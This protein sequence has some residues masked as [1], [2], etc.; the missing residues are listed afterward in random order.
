[1]KIASFDLEIAKELPQDPGDWRQYAPLGITCAAAALSNNGQGISWA[2]QMNHWNDRHRIS[3]A[4][5]RQIVYDLTELHNAGFRIVTW[6]GTGF[7]FA[8]LAQESGMV[9]ECAHLALN[10][11]DMMLQVTFRKGWY[12]GLEAALKGARLPGKLKAVQLNSGQYIDEMN[13]ALAPRLWADGEYQAVLAYLEDDVNGPLKLAQHIW[14]KRAICWTSKKGK[15]IKVEVDGLELVK[16]LFEIPEPDTSWMTNPPCRERLVD[17]IP[18]WE[19]AVNPRIE[20][21][22]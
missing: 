3:V 16:D 6:N 10:H 13:G 19:Q 20:M 9:E 21:W 11:T 8:V 18:N 5:C 2:K 12:L 14:K 7:D 15:M 17:W 1:M 4:G 22:V